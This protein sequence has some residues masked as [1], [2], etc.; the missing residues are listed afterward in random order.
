MFNFGA[1]KFNIS[2]ARS[3]FWRKNA[4][5]RGN[6]KLG[7]GHGGGRGGFWRSNSVRMGEREREWG[8]NRERES[9]RSIQRE[10]DMDRETERDGAR[11]R[12][13]EWHISIQ[14]ERGI[15]RERERE[16]ERERGRETGRVSH[17]ETKKRGGGREWRP[18]LPKI[19]KKST[20]NKLG[21]K[22]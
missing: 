17:W 10:R 2:P 11:E 12:E 16:G 18:H 8:G 14:N 21:P 6:V 9:D 4:S 13:R 22:P 19:K 3:N 5:H 7:G 20:R 1:R 15:W